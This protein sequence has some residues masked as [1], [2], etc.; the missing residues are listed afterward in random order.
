MKKSLFTDSHGEPI[1]RERVHHK[2]Q[3]SSF[4]QKWVQDLSTYAQSV[5]HT[6]MPE[7]DYDS[8]NAYVVD[9]NRDPYQQVYFERRKRLTTF[10]ILSYLYPDH[11]EYCK[12]LHSTIWAICGEWT[13][14]LP[15]HLHLDSAFEQSDHAAYQQID[16]F[17]AETAFSLA[18]ILTMFKDSMPALIKQRITYE[19]R[20][21]VLKPFLK[22]DQP[23]EQATH[24]WSAVCAGSIGACAMYVINSNEELQRILDKC[25]K[26]VS[27]FILGLTDE[28]VCQ[29]GYHYWQYGFGYFIYFADL[30]KKHTRGKINLLTL[31]KINETAHF[32]EK[33]FMGQDTVANFS[34]ALEKAAPLLGLSYYLHTHFDKVHLPK[35]N[36]CATFDSDPCYRFAPA[37]RHFIWYDDTKEGG[38]WP[39]HTTHFSEAQWYLSTFTY[40]EQLLGVALKGGH[41]NEPHNHNDLGHFMI[42][43]DGVSML[44]D[45]GAGHYTKASFSTDR[46][47]MLSNG[48]HGHSVPIIGGYVQQ[49]GADSIAR[50]LCFKEDQGQQSEY[51]LELTHAYSVPSLQSFTRKWEINREFGHVRLTDSFTLTSPEPV[52]ERFVSLA[53]NVRVKPG[54]II[55]SQG[56]TSLHILFDQEFTPTVTKEKILDHFGDVKEINLIDFSFEHIVGKVSFTCH[57]TVRPTLTDKMAD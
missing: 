14:C 16:L 34:D 13:W 47:H 45:I 1:S 28:G 39:T 32:Q 57:F 51:Q 25:I 42:Y 12:H 10:S 52:M 46:Y 49:Q 36:E 2:I 43:V 41:N 35:A 11:S 6:P 38:T 55:I 31:P 20:R 5:L 8:F 48:S 9:G 23:W 40:K 22:M 54:T 56:E 21:R 37:I 30:L 18:E 17:A 33:V 15:A 29:E 27:Y 26:S 4:L 7:L 3:Q 50:V 44:S 53:E 24:N 19:T